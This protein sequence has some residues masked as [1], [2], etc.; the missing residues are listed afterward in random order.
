MQLLNQQTKI[1]AE[2]I[3]LSEN[4]LSALSNAAT[5]SNRMVRT[6][7]QLDDEALTAWLN[8]QD[9]AEL[10]TLFSAHKDLGDA[11]NLAVQKAR[12]TLTQSGIPAPG[13]TVDVRP[14]EVKLGD[15]GRGLSFDGETFAV[16]T[17]PVPEPE[18][19]P[20]PAPIPEPEPEPEPAPIPE[21]EPFPE[22]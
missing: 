14:F 12:D 22:P 20:E 5:I 21:P 8:S 9:T 10:M 2:L 6:L 7:L 17:A 13:V 15:Q 1:N 3:K 4:L 19:E 16:S 11:I 18:P